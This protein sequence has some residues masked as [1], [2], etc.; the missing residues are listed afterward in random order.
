M[1][2]DSP[3]WFRI[4]CLFESSLLVLAAIIA[5]FAGRPLL[6]DFHW[7]FEDALWGISA[8]APPLALF[9]RSLQ[10]SWKP[11]VDIQNALDRTLGR[12]FSGFSSM[13]LLVVSALAGFSEEVLFRAVAQGG[14]EEALGRLGALCVAS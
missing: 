10:S 7:D 4:T 11:L 8:S 2:P 5:W 12:L 9:A 3:K 1:D 6:A 14:L 13:Q